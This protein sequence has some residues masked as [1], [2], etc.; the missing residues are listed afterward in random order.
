MRRQVGEEVLLRCGG[1]GRANERGPWGPKENT[2]HQKHGESLK[3]KIKY[4]SIINNE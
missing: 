1:P 2:L 4:L 3:T